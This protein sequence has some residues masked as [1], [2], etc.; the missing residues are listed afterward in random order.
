[1]VFLFVQIV[2]SV[3]TAV[4]VVADQEQL[5]RKVRVYPFTLVIFPFFS[6]LVLF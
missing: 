6:L 1:M 3:L 4:V 5:A 2:M